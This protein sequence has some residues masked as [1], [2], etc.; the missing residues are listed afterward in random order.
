MG[1]ASE[2]LQWREEELRNPGAATR[3]QVAYWQDTSEAQN[4]TNFLKNLDFI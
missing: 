3:K 2:S 4:Q 1:A